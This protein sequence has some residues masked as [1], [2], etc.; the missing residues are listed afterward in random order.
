MTVQMCVHKKT[1]R[2]FYIINLYTYAGTAS[3]YDSQQKWEKSV[4]YVWN[5][6]LFFLQNCMDSL[7]EAF[8]HTPEPWH[9]GDCWKNTHPLQL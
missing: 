3:A 8:T 1:C 6:D 7:Q 2:E 5:M 4:L 9:L